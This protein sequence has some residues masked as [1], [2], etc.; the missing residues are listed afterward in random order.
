MSILLADA[1]YRVHGVDSSPRM[2]EQARAKAAG[3]EP[4]PTF[5]VADVEAVRI[6]PASVDVVL[7]RHVLWALREPSL[8]LARWAEMLAPGGRL[9]LIEGRWDTGAGLAEED[10]TTMLA[11]VGRVTERRSLTDPRLWG[12]AVDDERYLLVGEAATGPTRSST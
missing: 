5:E 1:G 8:V 4:G 7:S 2:I 9:V 11:A 12:R 6:E 10:A 3:S